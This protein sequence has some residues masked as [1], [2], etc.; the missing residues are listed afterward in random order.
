MLGFVDDAAADG[1]GVA[2]VLDGP[3]PAE[4][5]AV[6]VELEQARPG[7]R[8][9]APLAL[10]GELVARGWRGTRRARSCG[11]SHPAVEL[12]RGHSEVAAAAEPQRA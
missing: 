10:R 12:V 2:V 1:V 5:E 11:V 6:E 7:Y 3:E 8:E 4:R 9:R